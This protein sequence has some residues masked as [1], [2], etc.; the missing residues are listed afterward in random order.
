[1]IAAITEHLLGT[2]LSRLALVLVLLVGFL[3]AVP[4][5]A[6]LGWGRWGTTL[7]LWG[8][9]GALIPTFV[10]RVGAY[11]I[12]FL[13]GAANECLPDVS[14]SWLDPDSL[15]NLA[16]LVPFAV[17][18]VVASRSLVIATV[19]VACLGVAIEV[20]QQVTA[21]GACERGDLI[22]NI[23]GG[24]IAAVLTWAALR[25]TTPRSLDAESVPHPT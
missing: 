5:A 20:G 16:L 23:G 8:L 15:G 14:P 3:A 13:P 22:R 7:A 10:E 25:A 24:L 6:V 4:L 11:D 17:G 18:L 1:M 21:L 12:R 9:G 2:P 19:S